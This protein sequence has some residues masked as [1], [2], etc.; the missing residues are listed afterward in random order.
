MCLIADSSSESKHDVCRHRMLL[1]N[2]FSL[3]I[4]EGQMAGKNLLAQSSSENRSHVAASAC[5]AALRPWTKGS[6]KD[7]VKAAI[8][9]FDRV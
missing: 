6:R 4:R 8:S 9:T 3:S 2:N 5:R 1:G 7:L